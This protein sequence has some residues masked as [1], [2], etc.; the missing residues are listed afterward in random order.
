VL[1]SAAAMASGMQSWSDVRAWRK[2]ARSRLIAERAAL[3]LAKRTRLAEFLAQRLREG[4]PEEALRHSVGFYWPM[5]GEPDLRPFVRE[6]VA[7]GVEAALPVV[8]VKDQPLEFWRWAPGSKLTRQSVWGIPIPAERVPM[9]PAVLLAPLVGFDEAGYRLG[10]GGGYYDRT[11]ASLDLRPFVIGVGFELG[12]LATIYPQP[13]D[14]PMDLI[15]TEAA[16]FDG[17]AA[18][19][20][21]P[22]A[23]RKPL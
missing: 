17:R 16:V 6:L 4:G 7:A 13:H 14:V 1:Y 5:K 21:P 3:P 15:V 11:L 10:Y 20:R 18:L 2:A 9:R 19:R 8:V 22:A 23:T 12:R